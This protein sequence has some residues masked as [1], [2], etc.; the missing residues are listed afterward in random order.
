MAKSMYKIPAAINR[1]RLD[2]EITI[3]GWDVSLR[4]LPLKIILYWIGVAMVL[5][6][7]LTQSSVSKSSP[8]LMILFTIWYIITVLYL[9]GRTKTNEMRF[10]LI[11]ALVEY[12]PDSA[13][14]I[15]ARRNSNPYAFMQLL[16]IRDIDSAGMSYFLD[17]SIGQGY[18]VV[19]S[20]SALLFD[21]DRNSI[22]NRV[23]QFWRKVGHDSEWIFLTTKEPQRVH[24]QI[25]AVQ[26]QNLALQGGG[27][28]HPDLMALL[29]E[30]YEI[31]DQ[32]VGGKFLS[33]HQYLIIKAKNEEALKQAHGILAS[34]VESSSLMF[35]RCVKLNEEATYQMLA[36]LYKPH[37]PAKGR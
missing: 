3:S 7:A 19:G 16:G 15:T 13:R 20:A 30:K 28:Y 32:D 11:P 24:R 17:G 35:K 6:W 2:H 21:E 8:V 25:A 10:M 33:M 22:L 23:D 4:P 36:P 14:K 37:D 26:R 18:S 29:N 1:S 31:L 27:N 9:G 12:L 5:M 34:E